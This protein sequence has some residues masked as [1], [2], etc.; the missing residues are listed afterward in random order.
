MANSDEFLAHK[1]I[2]LESAVE[3][4]ARSRDLWYDCGFSTYLKRVDA[5]PEYPPVV[6]MMYFEGPLYDVLSQFR[7]DVLYAE[8]EELVASLGYEYQNIDGVTVA[9]SI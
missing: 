9:C 1:I 7:D 6:S 2:E 5:E 8:F 4:W 3:A